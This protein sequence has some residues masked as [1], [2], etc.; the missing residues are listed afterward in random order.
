MS[1]RIGRTVSDESVA[2][3]RA[4]EDPATPPTECAKLF[5][6][7]I[8]AHVKYI[9]DA[10]E[11]YGVDR[12]L[13]GLKQL[14]PADKPKPA[15]FTDPANAYS[16]SWYLSTSQLSSEWFNGYGWSQVIDEG[17]GVAYMINEDSLSFNVVSK[18]LGSE[19]LGYYLGQAA[20]DIREIMEAETAKEAPKA[21]L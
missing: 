5:R 11:G 13:F 6:A 12:H 4:A 18:R 1:F 10:S 2:F 3:C 19:K 9:S 21:K 20:E 15:I 14:L 16:G 7:A 17:F 8:G